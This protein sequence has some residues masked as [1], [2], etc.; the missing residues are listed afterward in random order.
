MF[1]RAVTSGSEESRVEVST[2]SQKV[3]GC[4]CSFALANRVIPLILLLFRIS[5]AQSPQ[6]YALGVDDLLTLEQLGPVSVSPNGEWIAVVIVR[7]M[8]TSE[9]Y[10][11]FGFDV[12]RADVWLVAHRTG[13]R[14]NITNGKTDGSGYWNPVWSPDS[15]RLA[16][17]S[18][19]GGDDVRPYVYSLASGKLQRVTERGADLR[20]LGEGPEPLH[21]GMVWKDSTTLLCPVRPEHEVNLY[22]TRIQSYVVAA[23]EWEKAAAGSQPTGSV[24]ESGREVSESEHSRG[25]L[26]GIDLV[27]GT[28]RMLAEGNIRRVL[29]SPT[30]KNAA[31][32]I[33]T[34]RMSQG[35][36]SRLP[37]GSNGYYGLFR[38]RLAILR[39]QSTASVT[40]VQGLIDPKLVLAA[41]EPHSWSPDGSFIAVVGRSSDDVE[42]AIRLSLV[43]AFSGTVQNDVARHLE[44]VATRWSSDGDLLAF[45]RPESS[46]LTRSD[47]TRF[48]WWILDH[49]THTFRKV[50]ERLDVVPTAVFRSP[51]PHVVAGIAS[52]RLWS[53]DLSSG[54]VDEVTHGIHD[55]IEAT[56]WP[57]PEGAGNPGDLIVRSKHGEL[58][59]VAWNGPEPRLIPFPRPPQGGILEAFLPNHR[60]T[61]FAVT[62]SNGS[63]LWTGDGRPNGFEQV[64]ALNK[65][66]DEFEH[67]ERLLIQYR[68]LEGD[69][70]T[71]LLLL[72]VGY[73]REKR[74][75]LV[76][77]VYAGAVVTDTASEQF[78][79]NFVPSLNLHLLS[80][81]GYAV[82]IP[83]IPLPSSSIG[84]D[85]W[86]EL[87]K[88]VIPAIERVIEL[89]IADPQKVAVMGHSYGGYT[90]YSLI[91]YTHRFK[92][93]VAMA[94]PAN[95]V[96]LYGSQIPSQRY[97]PYGDQ[98]QFFAA[99]LESGQGRM[100][101]PPWQNLWRY[102]RN[103]PL[104]YVDRIQTPLMIIQGD[105][106]YVPMQQ[107]EELFTALNRQGKEA[108]LVR[109]WGEGHVISSPAN[110]RDMWQRIFSWLDEHLAVQ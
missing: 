62:T 56:V 53:L 1:V 42:H 41:T 55:A 60:L 57:G 97:D 51:V 110:I 45:A 86:I 33:E 74:Y 34:G 12:D 105:I 39:L 32:I 15:K 3:C 91:T 103:S 29:V 64:I 2:L 70:L 13:D 44:V 9:T 93:A 21:Y 24:L 28:T 106:D 18:T 26:I 35:G 78:Q 95:L 47:T 46:T 52:G 72:P 83:S 67:P 63:F 10:R 16:L 8:T 101:Y 81:H 7:S 69:S 43:S 5:A 23:S 31:L 61:V 77:W 71:G 14:R 89:G 50:T 48:D 82:L 92:A 107:G 68:S 11:A 99:Y 84:S 85:P 59:R 58:Y 108:K 80:A 30:R 38:T 75:P 88:G 22:N 100:G 79:N 73:K 49:K 54:N 96:S 36:I 40:R 37:S 102:L 27:T 109:Y 66:L 90:T 104:Y 6:K 4:H 65:Q 19:H 98:N 76:A 20:A 25:G 94:G 17:L 87:P